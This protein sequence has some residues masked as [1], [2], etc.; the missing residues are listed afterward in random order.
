MSREHHQWPVHLSRETKNRMRKVCLVAN[1]GTKTLSSNGVLPDLADGAWT[2]WSHEHRA[3]SSERR[4]DSEKNEDRSGAR[5]I[6]ELLRADRCAAGRNEK[7]SEEQSRA[8]PLQYRKV[9]TDKG[10]VGMEEEGEKQV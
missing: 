9:G 5:S 1:T 6:H 10:K 4:I 7:S 8:R 3:G 2:R